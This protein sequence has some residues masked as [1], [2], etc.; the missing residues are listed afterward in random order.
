MTKEELL[1]RLEYIDGE[2]KELES[3]ICECRLRKEDVYKEIVEL[4]CPHKVGQKVRYTYEYSKNVGSTWNPKYERTM[5]TE[6]AV[7]T[8]ISPIIFKDTIRFDYTFHKL[9]KD[10]TISS[11]SAWLRGKEEWLDEYYDL[12]K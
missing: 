3:Q 8:K 2:I 7:C 4:L 6:C 12:K 5:K 9:K 11:I 10:G 1:K